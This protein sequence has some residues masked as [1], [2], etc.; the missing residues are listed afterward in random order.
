MKRPARGGDGQRLESTARWGWGRKD[1]HEQELTCFTE[2]E[3]REENR[4]VE[5]REET[6]SRGRG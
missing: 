4:G 6:G 3:R 2:N 5:R 1:C